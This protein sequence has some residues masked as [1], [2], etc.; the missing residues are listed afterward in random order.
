MDNARDISTDFLVLRK[1]PFSDTSLV[2]A[3]IS[4]D[5]GQLHFLA[6]GALRLGKRDFPTVDIFRVLR[7]QFRPG[8]G[9]LHRWRSVELAADYSGV[10]RNLA[11]FRQAGWLA[12]FALANVVPGMAHPH[13]YAALLV[14]FARLADTTDPAETAADASRHASVTGACLVF[15]EESG[16]LSSYEHDPVAARQGRELLRLGLGEADMPALTAETWA[17]LHDWLIALLRHAECTVPD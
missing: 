4:P 13:F 1:T 6:Q 7:V 16:L 9:E 3:G 15:L 10:A 17:R 5:Q 2:V 14:A 11:A 8:R 12:R